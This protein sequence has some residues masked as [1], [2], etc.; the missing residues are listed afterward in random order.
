MIQSYETFLKHQKCD[1]HSKLR[2]AIHFKAFKITDDDVFHYTHSR[3][4]SGVTRTQS[5]K[6]MHVYSEV[7]P[8]E[9]ERTIYKKLFIRLKPFLENS[10]NA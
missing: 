6:C 4:I 5:C 2:P 3:Q 8:T 1:L 9:F 7:S 10:G